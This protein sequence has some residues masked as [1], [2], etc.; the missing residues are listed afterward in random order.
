MNEILRL[1]KEAIGVKPLLPVLAIAVVGFLFMT[2]R[3]YSLRDLTQDRL[4]LLAAL[5]I[6]FSGVAY[7]VWTSHEAERT[8]HGRMGIYV[9]R[10]TEDRESKL[11]RALMEHLTANINTKATI[12]NMQVEV[13]DLK[14]EITAAEENEEQLTGILGKLNATV[15][16]WGSIVSDK[17]AY[18]RTWNAH[19]K[20]ARRAEP[21]D[22]TDLRQL[23]DL[24]EQ[25][26]SGVVEVTRD[27]AKEGKVAP[28]PTR[29]EFAKLQ[30]EVTALRGMLT[31]SLAT[32]APTPA[33]ARI[34]ERNLSAVMIAIGNYKSSPLQGPT[35]DVQILS[36]QLKQRY[37][38][39]LLNI[40]K[41]AAATKTGIGGALDQ[42]LRDTPQDTIL[43][44]FFSGHSYKD[45]SERTGFVTYDLDDNN[46]AASVL[47]YEDV[48]RKVM[49]EHRRS[50][51]LIDGALSE[52]SIPTD[53][54][55]EGFVLAADVN[56]TAVFE[57]FSEGKAVGAFTQSVVRSLA[58]VPV[59]S[60]VEPDKLYSAVAALLKSS[61]Y[62]DSRPVLATG[63]NAQPL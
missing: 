10:L 21:T 9:A 47:W 5:A 31:T 61:G 29:D 30:A 58:A 12:E 6:A 48:I 54:L 49:S 42:A 11:Q 40:V 3:G 26:W 50:V 57:S 53:V 44:V 34:S 7:W 59:D 41:D 39:M 16:I 37:P 19:K 24:S 4:F 25:V 17:S 60:P 35:N 8:L 32:S 56:P 63:K 52:R 46:F 36:E 22:L 18:L 62:K 33:S 27:A 1:I 13:R 15:I 28:Y 55:S 23:G 45:E 51:I 14:R 43:F 20:L 38:N 2:M